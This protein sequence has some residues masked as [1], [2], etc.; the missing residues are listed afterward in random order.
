MDRLVIVITI[1]LVAGLF[2]GFA[3]Y[4]SEGPAARRPDEP[5]PLPRFLVLGIVA[6]ACVPLFLSLIQSALVETV[7]AP[8]GVTTAP[9]PQPYV[10]YLTFLGMCLVAAFSAKRFLVS[11][12]RQVLQRVE[13]LNQRADQVEAKVQETAAKA[14][15]AIDTANSTADVVDEQSVEAKATPRPTGAESGAVGPPAKIDAK[16]RAV[17][18]SLIDYSFRTTGVVAEEVGLPRAEVGAMLEAMAG[19]H[20]V[21]RSVS[22]KTGGPRWQIIPPGV[23]ALAQPA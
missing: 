23:A 22:P 6:S 19:R 12:S 18:S 11:L 2:G 15:A 9:V 13:S 10:A 4:L 21:A 3:G 8:G 20:L 5:H 7:F 17:L 16:E 14:D 1:I